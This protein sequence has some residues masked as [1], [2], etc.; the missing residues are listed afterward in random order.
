MAK[1]CKKCHFG[2]F[3]PFWHKNEN[4]IFCQILKTINWNIKILKLLKSTDLTQL[5]K[6]TVLNLSFGK[7]LVKIWTFQILKKKCQK[8]PKSPIFTHFCLFLN[9]IS[10]FIFAISRKPKIQ[11]IQ[12]LLKKT[13]LVEIY[14]MRY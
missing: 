5:R 3:W 4:F 1:K 14:Q 9:K 12:N 2:Q 11:K 7:K 8:V 6:K 13:Y 10:K